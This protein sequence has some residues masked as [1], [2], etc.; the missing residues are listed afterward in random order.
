MTMVAMPPWVGA[1]LLTLALVLPGPAQ[2]QLFS[3]EISASGV[4]F[5]TYDPLSASDTQ[6]TGTVTVSCAEIASLLVSYDIELTT[7]GSG[8]YFSREMA[9]GSHTLEYQL[10]TDSARTTV[11]GDG[12]GSTG[13]VHDSYLVYVTTHTEDYPVYGTIPAGQMVAP[14]S[15]ADSITATV[16]Y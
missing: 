12:S 11:W 4:S 16:I 13:V 15:Y 2:A 3:C 8:T 14:G 10:Y 1:V 5:G 7:G 9:A 6:V